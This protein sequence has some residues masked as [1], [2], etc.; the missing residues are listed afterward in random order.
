MNQKNKKTFFL[1][2]LKLSLLYTL[3]T[4]TITGTISGL[5]YWRVD[6]ILKTQFEHW[7][8]RLQA[9]FE[10]MAPPPAGI[11]RNWR[12]SSEDYQAIRQDLLN[13]IF[14]VNFYIGAIILLA[15]FYV[16]GKTLAPLQEALEQQQRFTSDAAHELRTPLTALKTGLEADLMDKKKT[17]ATKKILNNYLEDVKN[18]ENLTQSLLD[19]AKNEAAHYDFKAIS[20]DFLMDQALEKLKPLIDKRKIKIM[21][22][23]DEKDHLVKAEPAAIIQ[24]ITILLDNALKYSPKAGKITI[25]LSQKNQIYCAISDQGPGIAKEHLSRIFDRFYQVDQS[26][27]QKVGVGLGLSIAKAIIDKHDGFLKVHSQVGKGT[28]FSFGLNKA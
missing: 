6:G 25:K 2:R 13:Q 7:Q 22:K 3:I 18:L 26:R 21:V 27:S 10:P 23:T 15:S 20:L 5:L 14:L 24:V 8:N 12:V 11:L 17:S 16:S 1:A 9:E 19:L 4:L 28:T